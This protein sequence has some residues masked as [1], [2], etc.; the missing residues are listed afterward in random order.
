MHWH[1]V[2]SN[3]L[4]R[5][6]WLA[7]VLVVLFIGLALAPFVFTGVKA[8]SVAAKVV[9]KGVVARVATANPIRCAPVSTPWV[10]AGATATATVVVAAVRAAVAAAMVVA[11]STRCA[12]ATA[13]SSKA[14]PAR[15]GFTGPKSFFT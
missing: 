14:Q 3:D 10:T 7:V 11:V 8:L 15:P 9:A 4:P 2:L 13:V 12:P 1:R 5:S 6:R